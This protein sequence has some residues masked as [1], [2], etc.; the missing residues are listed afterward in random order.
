MGNEDEA[1]RGQVVAD[2]AVVY[3]EFFV[4]AL[5]GQWPTQLLE[6]ASVRVGTDVLDVG[7]GTGCLPVRPPSGWARMVR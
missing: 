4:P 1:E 2:A 3:E 6:L 7:C 5:F